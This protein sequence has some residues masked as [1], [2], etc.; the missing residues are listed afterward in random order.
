MIWILNNP[1][2]KLRKGSLL[3]LLLWGCLLTSCKMS[4]TITNSDTSTTSSIVYIYNLDE[5][6]TYRVELYLKSDQSLV[7]SYTLNKNPANDSTYSFEEVAE[8]IYYLS[9]FQDAGSVE[10]DKSGNF[11]LEGDDYVCF[12]I[13]ADDNGDLQN[14]F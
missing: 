12:K 14:C 10:T 4:D 5:D 7:A 8:G 3:F 1:C 2:A 13:E 6:Y 11:Y 9:I